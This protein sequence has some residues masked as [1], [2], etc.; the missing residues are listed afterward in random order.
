MFRGAVHRFPM[1]R[2]M[3]GDRTT[4]ENVT[5]CLRQ[6]CGQHHMHRIQDTFDIGADKAAHANGLPSATSPGPQKPALA[7]KMTSFP[8]RSIAAV[9]LVCS[10]PKTLTTHG[11]PTA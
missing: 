3:A 4:N 7:N 6:E 2:L 1:D 11:R 9:T 10:P 8:H 5:G